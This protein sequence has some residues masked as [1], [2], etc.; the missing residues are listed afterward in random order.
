MTERSV[1]LPDG[2]WKS[3]H[4]GTQYSGKTEIRVE[5]PL[6]IIPVFERIIQ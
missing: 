4:D 5:T 1:Y 3:I 2:L 6:D